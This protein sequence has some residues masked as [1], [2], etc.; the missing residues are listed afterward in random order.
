MT[1]RHC[2]TDD[3]WDLVADLVEVEPK[4]TGRPP[5]CRRRTLDGILWILKTGAAWR[6]LPGR[7]GKWKS[8]YD[9]FNKWRKDGTFDAI[10]RGLQHVTI[11]AEELDDGLW[12]IDGTTVR[13]A[14]CAAG[15]QKKPRNYMLS[16][17]AGIIP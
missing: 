9:V 3:Q 1:Q 2:F 4:A 11:D 5:N 16:R 15:P 17:S 12:C 14:C 13:A 6:D 7:F 8:V 10:L